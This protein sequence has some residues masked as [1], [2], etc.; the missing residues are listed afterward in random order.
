M[1]CSRKSVCTSFLVTFQR[2]AAIGT[3]LQAAVAISMFQLETAARSLPANELSP[4]LILSLC[5]WFKQQLSLSAIAGNTT[6]E[7]RVLMGKPWLSL[8]FKKPLRPP[9][10]VS[11]SSEYQISVVQDFT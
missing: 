11:T 5:N 6:R 4:F 2:N 1:A 3:T 9:C 8:P 10:V 7:R